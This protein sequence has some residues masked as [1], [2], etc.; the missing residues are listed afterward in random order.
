MKLELIEMIPKGSYYY[1]YFD[2]EDMPYLNS[3]EYSTAKEA[4][5]ALINNKIKWNVIAR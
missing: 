1:W 5:E 3:I 4:I 2:E